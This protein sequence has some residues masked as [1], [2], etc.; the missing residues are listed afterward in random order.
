MKINNDNPHQSKSPS[1]DLGVHD[2]PHQPKSP[3]GDLGVGVGVELRSEE[4]QEILGGVPHWILR[5]GITVL[6]LIVVILVTGS[7]IIK[8]P[9]II[10]SQVVLT[11][12]VPPASVAARASG[13]LKALFVKDN[14]EVRTG[15]YLAVIDNP[16]KTEDIRSLKTFLENLA[17]ENDTTIKLPDKELQAGNLQT[18]YASLYTTLFD[19]MEY[20]RLLYYPQKITITKER[21]G[22]YEKQYENLLSQQKITKEQTV[23]VHGQFLR[24]SLLRVQGVLS[25]EEFENAKSQYLQSRM[26]EENMRSSVRNMQIQI[27]QLKESLLDTRQQDVE[28]LN[29]LRSQIRAQVSQLKTEIQAW[30]LSYVLVAPID[31]VIT[32]TNYW[33]ANQNVDA[34]EAVFAIIPDIRG[35][36]VDPAMTESPIE[37]LGKA[38]LP[39]ARSGKVK[40][41]QKVNI[42]LE[43][44]PDNEYGILRGIVKNISLVP[45]Q[46]GQTISYTVE[47]ALPDG[48]TTT[49][50]KELP[51]LPNMQGQADI[52]TEDI[53]LLERF[54]LPLKKILS[55][56]L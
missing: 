9:D 2:N 44:F 13:K 48:L 41:G 24:D 29:S 21:I 40:V 15:D 3:S 23:L 25:G 36:R 14:Q 1:G 19:Y 8:Y 17:I 54:F 22:Q 56:S 45:M 31:G 47:I 32:F 51:Y 43:N 26:T 10:P 27:A 34:G 55:E 39:V 18:L 50:K 20:K 35:L 49:Y 7:A 52:I 33:V 37:I 38:S 30:E 4:F 46:T 28:K 42:R 5:W 6:A 12:S 53:S 11:G 16:A